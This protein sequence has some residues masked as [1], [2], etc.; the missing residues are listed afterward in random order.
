MIEVTQTPQPG[1][2]SVSGGGWIPVGRDKAT[3]GLNAEREA[4]QVS[5]HVTYHDKAGKVKV[6][7]EG[8]TSL[9]VTGNH[10]TF[11]GPCQVNKASGFTFTVDVVDN[12]E[13]GTNDIFRIHLSNGYEASGTLGGG[14]I[15]IESE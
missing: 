6:H 14:N 5:G 1:T 13:P 11:S 15:Q 8:I 3:F 7:S 2:E 4:G 9:T 12:G 10:A